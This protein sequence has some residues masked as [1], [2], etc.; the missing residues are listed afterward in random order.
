MSYFRRREAGYFHRLM[1]GRIIP[2]ILG[3]GW[4]FLEIGSPPTFW[5]LMVGLQ[6]SRHL[7]VCRLPCWCVTLSLYWGSRSNPGWLDLDPLDSGLCWVLILSKV[8]PCPLPHVSLVSHEEPANQEGFRG[9]FWDLLIFSFS[10][11]QSRD[12]DPCLTV[13]RMSCNSDTN[14]LWF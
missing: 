4:R 14:C 5:S 12:W 13:Q 11:C 3:K 8:V 9:F 2:T 10:N 7:W 1:S 6:L